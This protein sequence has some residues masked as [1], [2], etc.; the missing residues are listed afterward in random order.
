MKQ[1]LKNLKNPPAKKQTTHKTSECQHSERPALRQCL[2]NPTHLFPLL[3]LTMT[4]VMVWGPNSQ[5]SFSIEGKSNIKNHY[6]RR[7]HNRCAWSWVLLWSPP[8]RLHVPGFFF[9][10]LPQTDAFL[11]IFC[12]S[13]FLCFFCHC[14]GE[15]VMHSA[16]GRIFG[17][18]VGTV[19]SI[20]LCEKSAAQ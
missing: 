19:A 18:D 11:C 4:P 20:F 8:S 5:C 17:V 14:V 10:P 6:N 2:T 9:F 1:L 15:L 12:H 3:S 16:Q 13:F 7:A